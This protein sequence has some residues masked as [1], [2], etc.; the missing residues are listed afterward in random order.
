[1]KKRSPATQELTVKLATMTRIA[2]QAVD[3]AQGRQKGTEKVPNDLLDVSRA[4]REV[5]AVLDEVAN[6]IENQAKVV[7][8]SNWQS[9]EEQ[10]LLNMVTGVAD[11]A[12]DLVTL[13]QPESAAYL[14]EQIKAAL[15]TS[16]SATRE[17]IADLSDEEWRQLVEMRNGSE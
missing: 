11:A 12:A 1:M 8:I 13:A 14:P 10:E 6:Q 7:A 15:T 9:F 3:T 5:G 2:R 17:A 4:I 16:E